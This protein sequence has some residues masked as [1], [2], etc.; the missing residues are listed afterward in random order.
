ML[1]Q[2]SLER[3]LVLQKVNRNATAFAAPPPGQLDRGVRTPPS[4]PLQEKCMKFALKNLRRF[5]PNRGDPVDPVGVPDPPPPKRTDPVQLIQMIQLD[6]GG[7][8][9]P[10]PPCL[11][12]QEWLTLHRLQDKAGGGSRAALGYLTNDKDK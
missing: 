10:S 11:L 3:A 2:Y 6:R 8:D 12:S 5:A 4:Y 1:S 9:P 7:L